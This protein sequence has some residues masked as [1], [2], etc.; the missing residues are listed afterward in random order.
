MRHLDLFSGIGGFALAVRWL[1]HET[2]GFCEIDPWCRRVLD[3]HWPGVP[4]H[5]DI[6][7]LKGAEFGAIDLI[8]GG[9]PCQPFSVAGQR[10]GEDDP[11]HLWPA[12]HRIIDTARPRFVL[13]ENVAGIVNMALDGVLA[14]LEAI[15]YTA[16]AVVIPAGA[17]N[18]LHR[19]DRVWIMAHRNGS[20]TSDG[21]QRATATGEGG[22]RR[23]DRSGSHGDAWQVTDGITGEDTERMADTQ[24]GEQLPGHAAYAVEPRRN[25]RVEY[26]G[27]SDRQ[28]ERAADTGMA[29]TGH[30]EPPGW[31]L[32]PEGQQPGTGREARREPAP[33]GNSISDT[34]CSGQPRPGRDG[35]PGGPATYRE[36]QAGDAVHAGA[37]GN[38]AEVAR[39]LDACIDGLPPELVRRSWADGTWE[40]DL[41][42]VVAHEPERK[43]KLQAA[44]NAIVPVL[45]YEILRV[46]I[47]EAH[48]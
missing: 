13:A 19:R 30:A 41:P 33:C 31:N 36:G 6:R 25:A 14:D 29:D 42:R 22:E 47:G 43:Q 46:M 48:G 12:M 7:T 24:S 5:D 32:S 15:G 3:K 23:A 2:V 18:A 38:G 16:G 10:R 40:V 28:P 20:D 34:E 39:A 21:G 11:R 35:H 26:S 1:G 9:F 17:V 8:T 4:K 37:A 27:G 45:A 44:G